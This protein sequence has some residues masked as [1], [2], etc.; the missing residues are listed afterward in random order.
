[1]SEYKDYGFATAEPSH[2]FNYLK[3]P[4]LSMLDRD[5]KRCILDIGCGNGH[6]VGELLKLGYDA[7]GMDASKN[8]I[9]I[10]S[11]QYPG[12]FYLQD[13]STGKLPDQLQGI[14]FNTIVCTEVIE[15][16]YDPGE[17]IEFCKNILPPQGELILST[18][19]HGYLK[20]LALSLLNLWDSHLSPTWR[21]GHIKFWSRATLSTLLREK[22]FDV[23]DFS[24]TG[25][26]P[27]F[28]K[29]MI[30]KARL[31]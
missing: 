23:V 4:L 21:G 19:Y 27:Y 24:G 14:S 28:W 22:G 25:R 18:P 9:D 13:I 11:G 1:M 2:T 26:L 30:L 29:S 8:G 31:P 3:V 20:N 5:S 10:A 17:F 7:Y 15:H 12:R 16:L 6:L